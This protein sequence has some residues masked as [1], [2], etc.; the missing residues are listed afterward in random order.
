MVISHRHRFIFLHCRKAA[1]SALTSAITPWLGPSDVQIGNWGDSI[2]S[3]SRLNR[4]AA[5]TLL[6]SPS[7][8]KGFWRGWRRW[9]R[10]SGY[11]DSLPDAINSGIVRHARRRLGGNA[12]HATASDVRANYPG[13]FDAY[14]KFCVV[15]NPWDHALS[16]YYWRASYRGA[17]VSFKEFL[18]RKLD[19]SRPD[20]ECLISGPTT[21]WEIYTIDDA[22]AVDAVVCYEHLE[23][24][25]ARI[26]DRIGIEIGI[27][28]VPRAKGGIRKDATGAE[29][30]DPESIELVRELYS[31]EIDWFGY[32]FP[33]ASSTHLASEPSHDE[34]SPQ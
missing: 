33:Y 1:G 8:W 2:R 4:K 9:G 19:R 23:Q 18:C 34:A 13:C 29:L 21:N 12:A 10:V 25:L 30:Y 6:M 20:P 7:A 3:G 28:Q 16:D 22:L 32:T 11:R 26:S 17:D 27:D 14:F 15:R 5:T 31:Q 24:D